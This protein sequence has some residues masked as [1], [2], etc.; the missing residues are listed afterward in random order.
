MKLEHTQ[1]VANYRVMT[2]QFV[3]PCAA[4]PLPQQVIY[5]PPPNIL[6]SP[7]PTYET[8]VVSGVEAEIAM[9]S[10]MTAGD[11]VNLSVSYEGH[12]AIFV[13]HQVSFDDQLNPTIKFPHI[14]GQ[15]FVGLQGKRVHFAFAVERNFELVAVSDSFDVTLL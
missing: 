14:G 12:G 15:G 2:Q 5:L 9:A 6:P 11:W 7:F 13:S 3:L 4:E 10:P 8:L 1:Q